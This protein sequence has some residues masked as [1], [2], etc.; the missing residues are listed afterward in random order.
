LDHTWRL[1]ASSSVPAVTAQNPNWPKLV[2][3]V[4]DP[5]YVKK[6]ARWICEWDLFGGRHGRN[7][8]DARKNDAESGPRIL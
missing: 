2:P 4:L 7:A 6:L 1:V 8:D 3:V 5:E